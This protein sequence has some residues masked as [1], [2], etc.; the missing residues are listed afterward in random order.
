MTINEH[1]DTFFGKPVVEWERGAEFNVAAKC[2]RIS[3]DWEQY[4]KE[5]TWGDLLKDFL[6]RGG[7]SETTHLVVGAA[8]GFE[9]QMTSSIA[10]PALVEQA[11]GLPRLQAL[12]LGDITYEECELSWIEPGDLTPIWRAFPQLRAFGV[13]GYPGEMGVIDMP[14]LESFTIQCSGLLKRDVAALYASKMP[15]LTSLELWTG[16]DSYRGETTIG[17]WAK[18]FSGAL[19]PKLKHLGLRD[20]HYAD[21]IAKEIAKSPLLA[22]LESLD[23]SFGTLG[24]EGAAALLAAPAIRNLKRLDLHHHYMSDEMVGRIRGLAIEVNVDDQREEEDEG[25]RF[26]AVSE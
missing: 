11:K 9:G 12:F 5:I 20:S 13:R 8:E 21:E 26:V 2:P 14:K 23:L 1:L 6:S 24:D 4:E 7:N 25:D 22:R 15:E 10:V 19:F 17:D 3:L 18:L 16:D